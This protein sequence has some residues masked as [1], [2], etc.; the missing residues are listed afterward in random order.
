MYRKCPYL[1]RRGD[2]F[3]FRI[4]VPAALRPIIGVREVVRTLKTQ[5]R[6]EA[7]PKAHALASDA[8]SVFRYLSYN[9]SVDK[10]EANV[11]IVGDIVDIEKKLKRLIGDKNSRVSKLINFVDA[12]GHQAIVDMGSEDG[13]I[14]AMD[15]LMARQER[16]LRDGVM[17]L[18]RSAHSEPASLSKINLQ[19]VPLLSH[20]LNAFVD[21]LR[22]SDSAMDKKN[23]AQAWRNRF[24]EFAG[25]LPITQLHQADVTQF[26]DLMGGYPKDDASTHYV[27][28]SL[29]Q[30]VE[31]RK[32]LGEVTIN[33]ATWQNNYRAPLRV[34]LEYIWKK[35]QRPP[36]ELK[37][38]HVDKVKYAGNRQKGAEAQRH[39]EKDDVKR[40]VTSKQM[41][42]FAVDPDKVYI[43]WFTMLALHSGARLD[44]LSSLHP[45]LDVR[46]TEDGNWY[47]EIVKDEKKGVNGRVVDASSKTR[48]PRI[49]PIHHF[50]IKIGF[51][52]FLK[53]RRLAADGLLFPFT[54][55]LN[56]NSE[57]AGRVIEDLI[58][59]AGLRMESHQGNGGKIAGAHAFRKT[60]LS[61][62]GECAAK[63]FEDV[64]SSIVKRQKLGESELSEVAGHA[65]SGASS[66]TDY[67]TGHHTA[68]VKRR[69]SSEIVSQYKKW[70]DLLDYKINDCLPTPVL[71]R[72]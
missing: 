67:Y 37:L 66:M 56:S 17:P 50:L 5:S 10:V 30:K 72:V 60:F 1:Y 32:K 19:N 36:L 54:I 22:D 58:R 43:W 52:D 21:S 4:A 9:S 11:A 55:R 47:F 39:L 13:D 12:F 35:Y 23:R 38:L 18:S 53:N 3:Y 45:D 25:D 57:N 59:D 31:K 42:A 46:Q 20:E 69:M 63:M 44:E 41:N 49:V 48:E 62:G 29:S 70:V 65:V 24:L 51:V 26:L 14:R 34:F 68:E 64:E 71:P 2:Q 6:H 8:I 28:L 40:L 27:G 7:I 61:I 33:Q 16:M 15:A